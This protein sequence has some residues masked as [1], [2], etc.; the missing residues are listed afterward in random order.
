MNELFTDYG[1]RGDIDGNFDAKTSY[2]IGKALGHYLDGNVALMTD[3]CHTSK[4][5][6]YPIISGLLGTGCTVHEVEPMP[7]EAFHLYI[8]D[9]EDFS[10]GIIITDK[11]YDG[12]VEFT[13]IFSNGQEMVEGAMDK[14][15]SYFDEDVKIRPMNEQ[16]IL[17]KGAD[18]LPHYISSVLS[19][20]DVR[21]IKEA[22]ISAVVDCCK[23]VSALM[24]PPILD[25]VVSEMITLNMVQSQKPLACEDR[26]EDVKSLVLAHGYSMGVVADDKRLFIITDE[27]EVISDDILFAILAKGTL[28]KSQGA[29]VATAYS[30]SMVDDVVDNYG[31][32]IARSKIGPISVIDRMKDTKSMLGGDINGFIF[33]NHQYCYDMGMALAM[34]LDCIIKFGPLHNQ[35]SM[36]PD[37]RKERVDIRCPENIKA[38]AMEML[39]EIHAITAK[40]VDN[41]L[42]IEFPECTIRVIYKGQENIISLI[43]EPGKNK[44][45]KSRMDSVE[46]ELRKFIDY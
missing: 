4:V 37:H 2:R 15:Q 18:P 39:H 36:L 14:I 7:S 28:S 1:I 32:R 5:V 29:I 46:N 19:K 3:G 6:K 42:Y 11:D 21:A 38:S 34:V 10:G 22:N 30:S 43:C 41:N 31:G 35:Y 24:L 12:R 13:C 26:L 27:G 25:E 23:S 20:V 33:A 44:K 45:W 16:G 40:D 9:K 8:R 17:R